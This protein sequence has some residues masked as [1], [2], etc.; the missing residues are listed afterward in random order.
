M[1]NI[2][3]LIADDHQVVRLGLKNLLEG[4]NISVIAEATSGEEVLSKVAALKP[5]AV[6]LDVRMPGGDGL[7]ILGRLKLDYPELPVLMFSTY[8]NPTY[9][10]RAVA[11]GAS[12]YL[13]KS[14][15]RQRL[16]EC[17]EMAVRGESA[18]TREELR[19]VTGALATPR[20][21]SDV[22]VPLTQRESEVLRQLANGLTNKEIAN[23]LNISYETV[24]EHV[25]HIL[26]KIGVSDRTQAA[27]W[28]VRKG[29][30]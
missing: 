23:T 24:K 7:H 8:D 26:R 14:D 17:I 11:L 19:R 3:L 18:W 16:I 6:L 9:V 22:E 10:A 15:N 4:S 1:S 12:G 13:L 20:V 21:V 29:L 30:V 2:S 28:A 27:V 5:T 25:Q